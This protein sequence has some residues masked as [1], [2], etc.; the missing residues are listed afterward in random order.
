MRFQFNLVTLFWPIGLL[1]LLSIPFEAR[2]MDTSVQYL[3]TILNPDP[4]AAAQMGARVRFVSKTEVL[5][6]ARG[7]SFSGSNSGRSFLFDAVTGSQISSFE[8]PD[9]DSG[10]GF[11]LNGVAVGNE[12]IAISAHADDGSMPN[13]GTV[14]VFDK[15]TGGIVNTLNSPN[16]TSSGFFGVS[17]SSVDENL[18]IGAIGDEI[19]GVTSG[20]VYLMEPLS[21]GLVQTFESPNPIGGDRFGS[22]IANNNNVVLIGSEF[23]DDG[24]ITDSGIAYSFEI[25][26]GSHIQTFENPTPGST[27]R[28]GISVSIAGTRAIIGAIKD[29]TLA[30]DAGAVYIFNI[31]SG[32]FERTLFSPNAEEFE[33]FGIVCNVSDVAVVIGAPASSLGGNLLEGRA[34]LFDSRTGEHLYTF[35]NPAAEADD[36]FGSGCDVRGQIGVIGSFGDD[37][38]GFNAG[39]ALVF[40]I[41]VPGL[42]LPAGVKNWLEYD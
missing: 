30:N 8:N 31:G 11:G 35:T 25:Q 22:S 32:N 42:E 2:G 19:N 9:P 21:G 18:L 41:K 7:D 26:S 23:K 12:L 4:T 5:L 15:T 27:D 16:P 38:G 14:Y 33:D 36:Y 6:G 34:Y 37:R 1:S 3:R 28:F 10:D 39:A 17:L 24:I 20:A 40:S 29:D 13:G